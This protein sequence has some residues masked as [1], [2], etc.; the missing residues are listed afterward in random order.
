ML[1]KGI[2]RLPGPHIVAGAVKMMNKM[3]IYFPVASEELHAVLGMVTDNKEKGIANKSAAA[4][5]VVEKEKS[6]E[7]IRSDHRR[8]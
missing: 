6:D 5:I 3:N 4:E 8:S 1:N 7:I 2:P